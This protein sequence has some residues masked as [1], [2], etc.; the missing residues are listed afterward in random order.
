MAPQREK[1]YT[2]YGAADTLMYCRDPFI[3]L[4]GP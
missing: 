4:E 2:P 3:L 1:V